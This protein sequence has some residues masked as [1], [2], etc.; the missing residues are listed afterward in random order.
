MSMFGAILPNS[1]NVDL[2][3]ESYDEIVENYCAAIEDVE[4][5][6]I[7]LG[8]VGL[9]IDNAEAFA[10]ALESA[11]G[12][13]S[14]LLAFGYSIDDEFS[15]LVG[16]NK[17]ADFAT[18]NMDELGTMAIESIKSKV[19]YGWEVAKSFI[20][21]L[22]EKIKEF[23]RW[24]LRLF[25]HKK[26]RLEEMAKKTTGELPEGFKDKVFSKALTKTDCMDAVNTLDAAFGSTLIE[27]SDGEAKITAPLIKV[28]T[29]FGWSAKNGILAKS[30]AGGYKSLKGS[31]LGIASKKD[32]A[33]LAA[34][35]ARL[36]SKRA[37]FE[38]SVKEMDKSAVE[39]N[40]LAQ[41][42]ASAQMTDDE[43][44]AQ[45]EAGKNVSDETKTG[46]VVAARKRAMLRSRCIVLIGKEAN[47]LAAFVIQVGKAAGM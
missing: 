11:T 39:A 33:D 7:G 20:L 13:K 40:K 37:D 31:Q 41:K 12:D 35:T 42:A 8:A 30:N 14:A 44:K 17:P 47:N 28:L 2:G 27:D 24:V 3:T 25:D 32:V 16:F 4:S 43:K 23:G 10:G 45:K 1:E 46:A 15:T 22:I 29:K 26:Q 21:R 6:M 18:E 9:G 5:E 34:A 19:K 38:K 36:L